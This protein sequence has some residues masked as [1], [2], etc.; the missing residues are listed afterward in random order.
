MDLYH[1]DSVV[2]IQSSPMPGVNRRSS[3]EVF[4]NAL[5]ANRPSAKVCLFHVT[6][7]SWGQGL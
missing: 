4:S 6:A 5:Q 2:L 7:M 1:N 3:S